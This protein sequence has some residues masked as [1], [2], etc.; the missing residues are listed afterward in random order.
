[1]SIWTSILDA[2]SRIFPDKI[3][4]LENLRSLISV[5]NNTINLT[6]NNS[7]PGPMSFDD[8]KQILEIV[9]AKCSL[10]QQEELKKLLS[11]IVD[12][13]GAMIE[14]TSQ[15]TIE[16]IKQEEKTGETEKILSFLSGKVSISDL[17]IWRAALYL[18][19]IFRAHGNVS[20]LKKEII[21]KYGERGR[22]I[23]N[24]C[25][26][27]YIEEF[28]IPYYENLKGDDKND[29]FKSTY[30]DVVKNQPFTI[31]VD[32]QRKKDDII[33]E[34]N[35]KKSYGMKEINIHGIGSSNIKV[36][37]EVE[38]YFEEIRDK[39]PNR[40][41]KKSEIGSIS[42]KIIFLNKGIV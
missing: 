39:M 27:K 41:E 26:A 11:V 28:F 24:L 1:M 42:I 2:L 31:F 5:N 8:R 40:I 4:I 35:A 12:S 33:K 18:R 14:S 13:D 6:I 37:K 15:N 9:P 7:G 21:E 25:S 20:E 29:V 3:S 22:N 16:E 19:S 23:T 34:I 10:K 32:I 38:R 17:Y 30:E 36:V